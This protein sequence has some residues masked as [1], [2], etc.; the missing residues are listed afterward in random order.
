MKLVT[1]VGHWFANKMSHHTVMKSIRCNFSY[2][3]ALTTLMIPCLA[4]S[5]IKVFTKLF[6]TVLSQVAPNSKN[7]SGCVLA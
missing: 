5:S 1:V 4:I 2:E 6:H 3:D 7:Y